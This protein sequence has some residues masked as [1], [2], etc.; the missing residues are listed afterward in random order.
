VA[1]N[2]GAP[3]RLSVV[4]LA[5]LATAPI[6]PG[7]QPGEPILDEMLA[8][9]EVAVIVPVVLVFPA[10][11]ALLGR[12]RRYGRSFGLTM[13]GLVLGWSSWTANVAEYG[14]PPN[15]DD[16]LRWYLLTAAALVV[17]AVVVEARRHLARLNLPGAACWVV[18]IVVTAFVPV[19]GYAPRPP[20]DVVLP[21]PSGMTVVADRTDCVQ[22]CVRRLVVTA[23]GMRGQDVARR[24]GEHL[25]HARD[26]QATWYEFT[27][28]PD[29]ACRETGWITNPYTLCASI[30]I[31]DEQRSK[32]EIML[33]YAVRHDPIY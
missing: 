15:V 21:L 27:P 7:L 23:T 1:E 25:E 11:W 12:T 4:G 14:S 16:G 10:A 33:A 2:W 3:G 30:R 6:W 13:A 32:V 26:W 24:L 31:V 29:L 9:A 28:L 19:I 8:P 17:G 18:G 5:L 20:D 22:S